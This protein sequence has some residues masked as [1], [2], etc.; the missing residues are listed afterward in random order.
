[1]PAGIRRAVWRRDEGRC[2]FHGSQ[3]RCPETARLE[4]HH[5]VLFAAGGPTT[6][7]NLSLRCQAH[8]R[9]KSEGRFGPIAAR[10]RQ[11]RQA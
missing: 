4:F 11:S 8:N 3:G 10:S 7:A 5:V 9:H 2:A 1:M 6:E